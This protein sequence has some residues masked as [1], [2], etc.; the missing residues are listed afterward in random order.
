MEIVPEHPENDDKV[1]ET[2]RINDEPRGSLQVPE[3]LLLNKDDI[4][5]ECNEDEVPNDKKPHRVGSI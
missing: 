3:N 5:Y 4:I 2:V 1:L